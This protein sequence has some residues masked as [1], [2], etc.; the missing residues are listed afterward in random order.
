[1]EDK[2]LFVRVVS[3]E[4]EVFQGEAS[5]V[6]CRSFAGDLGLYPG[7][8]QLL[9]LLRPGAVR[10]KLPEGKEQVLY[11][12]GG[13]LEVQP[14]MVVVLADVIER[15]EDVDQAAAVE[16]M[17]AAKTLLAKGC[18]DLAQN[19]ESAAAYY[20]AQQNLAEASARLR[21]LGLA[22]ASL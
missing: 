17:E 8:S 7:H 4:G 6:F 15:P 16:A 19:P 2:T 18:S 1:M 22:S 11:V 5:S 10:L 3:Q 20:E 13:I 14:S 9:S 21:V 12:S